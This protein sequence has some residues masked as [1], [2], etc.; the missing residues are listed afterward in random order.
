MCTSSFHPLL[1]CIA[2]AV[3]EGQLPAVTVERAY[4][5]PT[6]AVETELQQ[7][8]MEVLGLERAEQVTHVYLRLSIFIITYT[9]IHLYIYTHLYLRLHLCMG[10]YSSPYSLHRTTLLLCHAYSTVSSRLII[11]CNTPLAAG[12]ARR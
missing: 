9:C 2:G 6:S 1:V 7:L 4:V 5:P 10:M 11:L 12:L 8:W 3:D